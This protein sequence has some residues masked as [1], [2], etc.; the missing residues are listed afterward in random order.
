MKDLE[1]IPINIWDDFY[2]D[3]YVPK[4]K[5]QESYIYVEADYPQE[6]KKEYL[7]YLLKYMSEKLSLKGVKLWME[8]YDSKEKYPD[9]VGTEHAW[10][11]FER[12]EIKVENLTHKRLD[13]L[14][15]ELNNAN[16]S[17]DGIPFYIYSE[18]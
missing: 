12:W 6:K 14:V 10:C 9:L 2:D 3:G 11:L 5:K 4:G 13:K 17:V 1:N 7:E 16:L 15:E 8:H 18:S